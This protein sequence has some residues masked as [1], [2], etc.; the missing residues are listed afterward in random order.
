[1]GTGGFRSRHRR[2]P[3]GH[4]ARAGSNHSTTLKARIG[5]LRKMEREVGRDRALDICFVPFGLNMMDGGSW[6]VTEFREAVVS[7]RDLEVT[8]LTATLPGRS[9]AELLREIER[10]GS[11]IIRG[12]RVSGTP[13]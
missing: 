11:E 1:M 3:A 13:E 12:H 9:R 7:L 6:T 4:Y 10:F 8:W 5:V 2:E